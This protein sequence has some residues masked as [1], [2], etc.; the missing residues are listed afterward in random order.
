MDAQRDHLARCCVI[1]A[2][3][4]GLV[5]VKALRDKSIPV[6]AYEMSDRVGGVWAFGNPNGKSAA[7]RSLHIDTSRSRLELADYPMPSDYPEY[8]HHTQIR[9]Y[10]DSY[11]DMFNLKSSV[12]FGT[13][14]ER[15]ELGKD[16]LWRITLG[17]GEVRTY[18]CLFICNGHHW[19]PRWPEPGYPGKFTG[20]QIHSAQS[21]GADGPV[22]VII[23][24]EEIREGSGEVT[25][26][27]TL[28]D[29]VFLGNALKIVARLA[30]VLDSLQLA[31]RRR[32][33]VRIP[34][35]ER[36]GAGGY[37]ARY[38]AA[39]QDMKAGNVLWTAMFFGRW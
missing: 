7:Y 25:V 17:N 39:R 28:D 22:R 20:T 8:P 24:P 15:A 13:S 3:V 21:P 23:R 10:L 32:H 2:G 18:D 31:R 30:G 36:V 11:A 16:K 37:L 38:R 27:A 1:G 35:R 19:D 14:V 12:R 6:D 4:S 5:T 9:R 26:Q 34:R 29:V 33:V